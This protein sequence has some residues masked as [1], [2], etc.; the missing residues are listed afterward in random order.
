MTLRAISCTREKDLNDLCV[1]SF[2]DLVLPALYA[3]FTSRRPQ[4]GGAALLT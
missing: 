2:L 4:S 3:S 1:A